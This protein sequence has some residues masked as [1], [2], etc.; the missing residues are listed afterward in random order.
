MATQN[1]TSRTIKMAKTHS[2][3][4]Q[5]EWLENQL[6]DI[7]E[8]FN[9]YSYYLS[10][11]CQ[12]KTL[13]KFK[14]KG[15]Y[16]FDGLSINWEIIDKK[17]Y[18]ALI[19]KT[20]D[21]KMYEILETVRDNGC[22]KQTFNKDLPQLVQTLDNHVALCYSTNGEII[23]YWDKDK[24]RNQFIQQYTQ[25]AKGKVYSV[26]KKKEFEKQ[27]DKLLPKTFDTNELKGKNYLY[28]PLLV[29][30]NTKT[31]TIENNSQSLK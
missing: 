10:A 14:N 20:N 5:A 18:I 29:K 8:N 23:P 16:S 31:P 17:L 2:N 3:Q 22:F 12:G 19:F 25:T 21:L 11:N 24:L 28:I 4:E 13:S 27:I 9:I 6:K 1:S 30:N 15:R 26:V 7:K